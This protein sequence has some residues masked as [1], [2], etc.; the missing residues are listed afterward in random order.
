MDKGLRQLKKA[1][2]NFAKSYTEIPDYGGYV[3]S[4]DKVNSLDR[5]IARRIEIALA[6][7]KAEQ[8]K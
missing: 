2:D 8:K 6:K 4:H 7:K 3:M 5:E 1:L